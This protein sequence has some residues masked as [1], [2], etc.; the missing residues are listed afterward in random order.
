MKAFL[1]S[2]TMVML[3]GVLALGQTAEVHAAEVHAQA[4]DRNLSAVTPATWREAPAAGLPVRAIDRGW[5]T[6][7]GDPAL[8]RLVERALAGNLDLVA[9][10]ARVSQAQAAYRAARAASQPQVD[11]SIAIDRARGLVLGRGVDASTAQPEITFSEDVD[12]FGRLANRRAAAMA[13]SAAARGDRDTAALLV[14]SA[15]AEG[16]ITLLGLQ[17]RLRTTQAT[18]AER[19]EELRIARRRAKAGY[20]SP[21]DLAQTEADYQAAA[22]FAPALERAIIGQEDALALL[23][24]EGPQSVPAD[25]ELGALTR[26]AIPHDMPSQTLRRRADVFAAEQRLV[27]AD[28]TLDAQRAALFPALNLNGAAGVALSTA[29]DHP[30]GLYSLGAG[31][32]APIAGRG[33]LKAQRDAAAGRRDEAIAAYRKTALTAL[34]EAQDALVA[35]DRLRRQGQA[36]EAQISALETSERLASLRYEAGYSDHLE[37]LDAHRALLAARLARAENR[38]DELNAYVD[39]YRAFG[40]GWPATPG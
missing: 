18:L 6:A 2:S 21:L 10:R 29:L 1:R 13:A 33:G 27:A 14:A 26:P 20:T 22:Q 7:F 31:L 15:T 4:P 25:A 39:L 35:V 5:W 24:G 28:R 19:R 32:V 37:L 9:A 3:T 8:S 34:K 16:Y 12:L 40:G 11:A 30:V 23:I 36:I 38:T 17:D